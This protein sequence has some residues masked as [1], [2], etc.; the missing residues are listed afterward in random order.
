MIILL[1]KKKTQLAHPFRSWPPF[2]YVELDNQQALYLTFGCHSIDQIHFGGH[3]ND[4]DDVY[5]TSSDPH[6]CQARG[7]Y[8]YTRKYIWVKLSSHA[9]KKIFVGG[10]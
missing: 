2:S 7:I 1:R 8:V 4:D 5:H 9:I 6:T 3:S 10:P